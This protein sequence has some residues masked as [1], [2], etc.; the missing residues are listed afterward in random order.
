[1]TTAATCT[2][3]GVTTYTCGSCAYN[4]TDSTLPA[5]L[6]HAGDDV[7][8]TTAPGDGGVAITYYE[9][10]RCHTAWGATYSE[11]A[12][13]KDAENEQAAVGGEPNISAVAAN[14]SA[15]NV[16]APAPSF[17]SFSV[18]LATS[19]EQA[20]YLYKQR[21][22]SLRLDGEPVFTVGA[23]NEDTYTDNTQTLRFTASLMVPAGVSYDVGSGLNDN[24]VTDFGFVYTQDRYISSPT[25]LVLGSTND[26]IH[27]MS[28][29]GDN[30]TRGAISS[31][32]WKGVTVHTDN[33]NNKVFTFMI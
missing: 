4:F 10:S 14:T 17:N 27:Y 18:Q 8:K 28:V 15:A 33:S 2:A 23:T 22:A 9:C 3:A 31:G 7:A 1:M 12:Y 19:G 11:G 30:S 24:V 16:L 26:K 29:A 25:D 21:G 32:N 20:T 5:A 13:S 6:G